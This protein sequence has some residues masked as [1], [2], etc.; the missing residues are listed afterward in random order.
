MNKRL[1]T[2]IEM[3]FEFTATAL[4]IIIPLLFWNLTSECYEIPKILFLVAVTCFFILLWGIKSI[5]S[6]KMTISQTSLSFPLLLLLIVFIISTFFAASRSVAIFG[7]FP[8]VGNGLAAFVTYFL[9]YLMVVT[10]IRASLAAKKIIYALL[11]T[12][13]L[14]S[15]WSLLSYFSINLLPL[16]WT[17]AVNFTPTGSGF[18]TCAILILLIPFLITSIV[19]QRPQDPLSVS[20]IN[21]I[22]NLS[23]KP[24]SIIFQ[25]IAFT[26]ILAL[27]LSVIILIGLLPI[28]I[29]TAIVS[30]L[31]LL[32]ISPSILKKNAVYFAIPTVITIL[33]LI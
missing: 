17:A 33:I 5:I 20:S 16:S 22:L 19:Y 3:I 10:N 4:V 32:S 24:A 12:G 31:T 21:S 7:N 1:Q 6:G 30:G 29:G 23:V 18:S 2:A 28:Y 15:I 27:F 9:F 25:K 8:R 14:L 13:I 26:I 11:F